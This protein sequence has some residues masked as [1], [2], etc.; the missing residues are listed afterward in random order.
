MG[1]AHWFLSVRI[2]QD[3]QKNITVDQSRYAK[4]ITKKYL[5]NTGTIDPSK[6]KSP[7]PY[8]FTASKTDQSDTEK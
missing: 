8:D 6:Y 2:M 3:A 4:N 5:G 7:L 1:Y